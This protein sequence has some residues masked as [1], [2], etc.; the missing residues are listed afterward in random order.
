MRSVL[1]MFIIFAV[2]YIVLANDMLAFFAQKSVFYFVISAIAC[3]FVTAIVVL[4]VPSIE[5]G[6]IS[7][8]KN[9][10]PD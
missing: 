9:T 8:E 6:G 3:L 4:G 2:I 5:K 7:N 10:P 1:G